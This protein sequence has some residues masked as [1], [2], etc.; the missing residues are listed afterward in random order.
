MSLLRSVLTYVGVVPN[1]QRN[2]PRRFF[3]F[4]S[5]LLAVALVMILAF[6]IW[7]KGQSIPHIPLPNPNGY[8]D[9]VKAGGV[10]AGDTANSDVLN[11]D[12]LRELVL[13][14][15]ETFHWL[16][17]GLTHRCAVPAE[18]AMTNLPAMMNELAQQKKLARLLLG[19][20]RFAEMENQPADAIRS[21]VDAIRLG[22]EISRGGFMIHRLVGIA[23]VWIG[24]SPL[25]SL[26][27]KLNGEQS[28]SLIAEL[29]K[30][31]EESVAWSETLEMENFF[32]RHEMRKNPNPLLLARSW[33]GIRSARKDGEERNNLLS[34]R[35]RLLTVELA[36]RCYRAEQGHGPERLE[37]LVPKHLK[38]VPLDPFNGKPL[39][40]RAQGTNWL[41]YSV[42]LDGVDDGGKSVGRSTSSAPSLGDL[43]YDSPR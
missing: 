32:A 26:A 41:L 10:V 12:H 7:I 15:A 8:D 14:N 9:F 18:S 21:Y 43:F 25:I 42:G 24:L 34:A 38:R 2:M 3:K 33:W 11:H 36:L 39:T 16:R 13:T 29:E 4:L 5:V 17:L 40:Y 37:E 30:I 27:P 35:L 23:D 31:D 1:C 22:N 20:G 19:E 6:I 28:R